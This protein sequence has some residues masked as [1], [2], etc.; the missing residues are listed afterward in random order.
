[1]VEEPAHAD[2]TIEN[3]PCAF[4]WLMCSSSV[5]SPSLSV[6]SGKSVSCDLEFAC[7]IY[8][9]LK[10]PN[11]FLTFFSLFVTYEYPQEHF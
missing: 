6:L 5:A 3:R 1:M 7:R 2:E 10:T 11:T 4:L 9:K 8:K